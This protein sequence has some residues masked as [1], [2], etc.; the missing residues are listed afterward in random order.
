MA[1]LVLALIAV[2]TIALLTR[3]HHTITTDGLARLCFE[4]KK[5]SVEPFA[6]QAQSLN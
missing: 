3:L 4:K 1:A 2:A 6:E 5:K